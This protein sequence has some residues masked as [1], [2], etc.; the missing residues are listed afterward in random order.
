M[1]ILLV[2]DD[3][4]L[5]MLISDFLKMNGWEVS[6]V[7][8]GKL[9]L[10][11]LD[12][13]PVDLIVMDVMMPVMDG[14]TAA[15]KMRERK[16]K[17]P[18]IFLTAR[19]QSED[20]LKGFEVGG[21][22]YVNKP[23]EMEELVARI[24]AIYHRVSGGVSVTFNEPV[25]VGK[26]SFDFQNRA[27]EFQGESKKLTTKEAE[28]LKLLVELKNKVLDRDEALKLIWGNATYYNGRSMDVYVT[29]LRKHL[30]EDGNLEIIN[31][32]GQGFKLLEK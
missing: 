7:V 32:H 12:A 26:Y 5:G 24:K 19:S 4:N 25:Q 6:L 1:N 8:N 15:Q 16:I 23:F 31:V 11:H 3:P 9:A 28:L 18:I 30:K 21:D 13:T 20:I 29:K 27:L 2:E 17:T 14:F 10:E 22:D